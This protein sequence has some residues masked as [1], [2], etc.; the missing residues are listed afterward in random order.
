[1]KGLHNVLSADRRFEVYYTIALFNFPLGAYRVTI[2]GVDRG[3]LVSEPLVMYDE[4]FYNI[5]V[6]PT[7]E[8]IGV[9]G[10]HANGTPLSAARRSPIKPPTTTRHAARLIKR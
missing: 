6:R 5:G 9:G 2:D 8:D 3:T 1:M 4:G 10:T 7:S